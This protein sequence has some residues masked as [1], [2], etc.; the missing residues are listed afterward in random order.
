MPPFVG[1]W[2]PFV[3]IGSRR[4]GPASCRVERLR[5]Y[6]DAV[7]LATRCAVLYSL[8]GVT[9]APMAMVLLL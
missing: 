1:E 8:S 2:S 3:G 7:R 9:N 6:P 4:G 5:P